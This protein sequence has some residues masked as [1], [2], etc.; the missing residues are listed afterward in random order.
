MTRM[1][2]PLLYLSAIPTMLPLNKT[3]SAAEFYSCT[4]GRHRVVNHI[5]Y[6]HFLFSQV[7]VDMYAK[8]ETE[9]L[10]YIPNNQMP[11]RAD[12]YIHLRD[13]VKRQDANTTHLGQM[14]V[15]L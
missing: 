6:F 1:G 2:T 4:V 8:R 5:V 10:N 3:V 7:L 11:L 13:A 9:K 12:N 15:L 14:A